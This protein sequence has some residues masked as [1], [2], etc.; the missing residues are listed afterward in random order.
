MNEGDE[1]YDDPWMEHP[2]RQSPLFPGSRPEGP[3]P[4]YSRGSQAVL[5][6]L[7]YAPIVVVP[8]L[9]LI[10]GRWLTAG[11]I[12]ILAWRIGALL[13]VLVAALHRYGLR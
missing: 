9:Y 4:R 12:G 8:C 11:L 10:T 2:S 3:P 13:F 5:A 1:R 7:L 6:S